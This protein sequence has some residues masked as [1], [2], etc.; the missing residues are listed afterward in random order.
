MKAENLYII[1]AYGIQEQQLQKTSTFQYLACICGYLF[2]IQITRFCCNLACLGFLKMKLISIVPQPVPEGWLDT[3][4]LSQRS[5][6]G[7]LQH[8]S[9]LANAQKKMA[10]GKLYTNSTRFPLT[11]SDAVCFISLLK[12]TPPPSFIPQKESHVYGNQG[13]PSWLEAVLWRSEQAVVLQHW[14]QAPFCHPQACCFH[15]AFMFIT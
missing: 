8:R 10:L 3:T 4:R 13:R 5:K 6:C 14:V 11:D 1:C 7:S 9:N 12:E 15:L 2:Q